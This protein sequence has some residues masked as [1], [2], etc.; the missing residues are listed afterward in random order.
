M[1][2]ILL[3]IGTATSSESDGVNNVVSYF[4]SDF[5]KFVIDGTNTGCTIAKNIYDT[6]IDSTSMTQDFVDGIIAKL[7]EI[8]AAI[9]SQLSQKFRAFCG[10]ISYLLG[11]ANYIASVTDLFE[12]LG[13]ETIK[14]LYALVGQTDE[15]IHQAFCGKDNPATIW[16]YF[17][18]LYETFTTSV[19][20]L[21][22]SL[23]SLLCGL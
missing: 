5:R 9:S 6:A 1:F 10:A 11:G 17:M 19:T 4:G 12:N 13:N 20:N 23:S 8:K 15:S 18:N 21:S 22:H 16:N 14:Y 3:T 7:N 2:V